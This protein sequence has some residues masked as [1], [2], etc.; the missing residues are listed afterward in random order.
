M[1]GEL[2]TLPL[3]V[4]VGATRLWLRTVTESVAVVAD[5]SG[6]LIDKA[7]GNT[8]AY[9]SAPVAAAERRGAPGASEAPPRGRELASAEPEL[10]STET[11]PT[12]ADTP[13]VTDTPVVAD[14][15]PTDSVHVSA[16]PEL[17]EEIAEPGAEDGAG[18]AL[19][20][21]E[22]WDGYSKMNADD[23]ID[24]LAGATAA[25]L[26]AIQ[27]Y[28]SGYRGRVTVLDAVEREL[29]ISTNSGSQR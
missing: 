23:V 16:E 13:T 17:V 28:E 11:P 9:Q 12:V 20:V 7:T 19:R 15:S 21:R 14:D 22:P 4:G 26:A 8:R 3:R 5:V 1:V 27:L 2:I 10:G 25:E 18:A 29:R 6:R 24:R